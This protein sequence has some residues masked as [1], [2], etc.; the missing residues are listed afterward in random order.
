MEGKILVLILTCVDELHQDEL[1]HVFVEDLLQRPAP[2]LLQ[3]RPEL[4]HRHTT[5]LIPVVQSGVQ[6]C[7]SE[8]SNYVEQVISRYNSESIIWLDVPPAC[9]PA[10]GDDPSGC[11]LLKIRPS[12]QSKDRAQ[13]E[14]GYRKCFPHWLLLQCS[15]KRGP[16]CTCMSP[17]CGPLCPY[18][19]STVAFLLSHMWMRNSGLRLMGSSTRGSW[20]G[21]YIQPMMKSPST[22]TKSTFNTFRL[23]IKYSYVQQINS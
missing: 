21:K 6:L 12:S 11:T 16:T 2:F 1:L 20:G 5:L 10:Y 7:P 18:M 4:L 8:R 19:H 17:L 14:V 3:P 23:N 22:W 15:D 9:P 13:H